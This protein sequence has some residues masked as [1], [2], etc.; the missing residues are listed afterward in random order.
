MQVR[1]PT[2]EFLLGVSGSKICDRDGEIMDAFLYLAAIVPSK[3]YSPA[4]G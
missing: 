3:I 2:I 1:H 4:R